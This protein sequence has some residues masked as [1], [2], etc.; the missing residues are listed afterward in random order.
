[1]KKLIVMICLFAMPL[2]AS[3]SLATPS[4]DDVV[5]NLQANQSKI[6]DMYAET[7]TTITSSMAMPGQES[8]GPQKMVQKGKMWTKGETKS[9]IEML[10][11]M[12]QVTITN[13]D[14]MAIIDSETGQ[15]VVQDLKKMREKSGLGTSSGGQMNL[16]KAKEYFDL[17]LSQKDSDYVI[18]GVPKKENKF[19]GKMEFYVDGDKWVPVKIYMYDAKGKLMS[20]STIEYQ[21]VGDLYVPAKNI[22][23]ISTPMGKM[24]V[25][26]TFE[27]IKVNEGIDDGEFRVE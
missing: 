4:L 11:P 26:M 5:H 12:K 6:H 17:T 22:S 25:E 14:K 21:Q 2:F 13:G 27:N 8:K 7:T 10:S 3:A 15:K 1:M 24:A 16:D 20:Q 9:K 23:N 18:T 19:L